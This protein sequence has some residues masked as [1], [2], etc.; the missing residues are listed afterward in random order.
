[1]MLEWIDLVRKPATEGKRALLVL[2]SFIAHI[3][4][5]VKQKLKEINTVPVVIPGGCNSE[6]QPLNV[7]LNK[8]FKSYV[9][10][11]WSDY[12]IEQSSWLPTQKKLKPPQKQNVSSWIS[13]GLKQLQ[14]KPDMVVRSFQACGI[15]SSH[16]VMH[17]SQLRE[18]QP[19]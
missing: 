17:P 18:G 19:M 1:M 8:P 13:P 16:N 15:A 6:V 14:K 5:A 4:P 7:S 3:T 2:G 9:K 10:Q 12:V 11:Y